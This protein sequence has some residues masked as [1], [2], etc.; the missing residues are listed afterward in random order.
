MSSKNTW[1]ALVAVAEPELPSP[2]AVRNS[3]VGLAPE[4]QLLELTSQTSGMA[5]FQWGDATAAYTL[6]PRPIPWSQL[7]GPCEVAWYWPD[8][9]QKMRE[10]AAHLLVTLVDEGRDDVAKSLC[11]TQ[12]TAAIV[13]NCQAVGVV[14]AAAG[15][16]HPPD[17]FMDLARDLSRE[18]LPLHLWIDFR[19]MPSDD[20]SLSLFTTGLEAFDRREIE[21]L[22]YHG[23]AQS[24]MDH[25]YNVAHYAIDH[26]ALIK[27][28]DTM[29]LPGEVQ[30][31]VRHAKS[32][33]DDGRDVLQLEFE[34]G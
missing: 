23:E 6:V 15:L 4:A 17:G 22:C 31:T 18:L 2:E 32:K 3:L 33:L 20:G 28:G 29:G 5:T 1:L 8:A 12:F 19:L 26:V 34:P 13:E 30:A 21:V 24:L 14:W 16:V 9:A 10:H 7:E 27:D 25:A 11:L